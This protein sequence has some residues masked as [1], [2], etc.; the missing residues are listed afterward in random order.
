MCPITIVS[1]QPLSK[2]IMGSVTL[3]CSSAVETIDAYSIPL[4]MNNIDHTIRTNFI[5]YLISK[6][7]KERSHQ[8]FL[9]I[10]LI[11]IILKA[12]L[13]CGWT[14]KAK[15]TRKLAKALEH[16]RD[17]SDLRIRGVVRKRS[18]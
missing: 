14:T 2:G 13:K 7:K 10:G 4:S 11:W 18:P 1:L 17:F 8:T 9:E 15:S 12:I 3:Q 5:S 6:K 16:S